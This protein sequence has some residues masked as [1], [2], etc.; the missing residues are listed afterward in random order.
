LR[1]F[2]GF[3]GVE[4]S[5][6]AP[7]GLD[8]HWSVEGALAAHTSQTPLGQLDVSWVSGSVGLD[9]A[10]QGAL[11]A[12]V[13]PRLTLAHVTANGENQLG[14]SSITQSE[15]LA[16]LG[17]RASLGLGLGGR[18]ALA[19]TLDAGRA[20]RGLVITAG[21]QPHLWLDGWI[22]AAGVGVRCEL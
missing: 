6:S 1:S 18:F 8:L 5:L 15:N 11:S 2:A 19:A 20:L 10:R 4:A 9:L 22:A 16:L 14:A 13:G 21:G 7:I 12:G 3:W 17:G